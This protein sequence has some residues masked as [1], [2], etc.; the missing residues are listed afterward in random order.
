M[1]LNADILLERIHLKSQARRW[2]LMALMV[3]V[4]ALLLLFQKFGQSSGLPLSQE[5]I[6]RVTLGE[7]I[8]DDTERDKLL[9]NIEKDDDIKAVILRIDSPG[10]TTVASEEVYLALRDIAA[11]KPVVA[12]M[13]SMA[14]SGGYLAA[15]G[16]DYIVARE[17]TITGSV[18]V[19][20]QTMEVTE[21]S[22]KLGIKPII[23]RSGALKASPTPVEKITPKARQM[24]EGII[25]DFYNYFLNLV[26]TR[27]AMT[28]EQISVIADGRVVSSRQALELNMIDAIGGEKQALAWL[29]KKRKIDESLEIRDHEVPKEDNPLQELLH[30]AAAGTIFENLST[31][32]LDG[33]VSIWQP[34]AL[35]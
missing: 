11:K 35:K 33:L 13:R 26:K 17:G 14:T 10:G 32:P 12:T 30:G 29:V 21:L 31:V 22:K 8:L 27:R 9:K 19:I 25:D 4:F 34:A 20:L 23:V 6:A 7:M 18:G 3:A 28:D 24:L 15:I 5:H 2:R 16:A 1:A